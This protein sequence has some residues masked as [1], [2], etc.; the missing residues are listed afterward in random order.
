MSVLGLVL[1][2]LAAG[3]YAVGVALQA[4]EA[5]AAPDEEALRLSLLR[6]LVTRRRWLLGTGAVLLGWGAQAAALTLA[7]ITV[8]QP[9]LAVSVV[10]LLALASRG[11]GERVCAREVRAA[12]AIVVGVA[13]LVAVS[14]PH[15]ATNARTLVLALGLGSL[16]VLAAAPYLL[17][18][19]RQAGAMLAVSAGLAYAWVGLATAFLA[20]A[21]SADAWLVSAVWLGA[22]GVAAL[23]GL[24]SEMT[25]LQHRSAVQV[26]PAVLVVQVL[27]ALL[28]APLLAG[29]TFGTDPAT[30]VTL[31][32]SVVLLAFGTRSL[33][34]SASVE[35][36]IAARA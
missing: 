22:A 11:F 28:L 26:F 18:R 20:D 23:G 25:A 9:A 6:R 3:L 31:A 35:R 33:A 8:V 34:G 24:L 7:P 36:V 27:V 2:L 30:I 16:A 5:H 4:A 17:R 15:G 10:V 13:G 1:A 14:P 29:E 12:L 32:V 19:R 21:A